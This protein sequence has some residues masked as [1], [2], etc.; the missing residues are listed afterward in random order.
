[1]SPADGKQLTVC[2]E[3]PD[4][5]NAFIFYCF[6]PK[7]EFCCTPQGTL[8]AGVT[9]RNTS[10]CNDDDLVFKAA[11]PEVFA[12]AA[13]ALPHV[14]TSR[15]SSSSTSLGKTSTTISQSTTATVA[16][17]IGTNSKAPTTTPVESSSSQSGMSSGAKAGLGVGITLGVLV[18][19]AIVGAV[20]FLRRKRAN[21]YKDSA[22]LLDSKSNP[23]P[24]VTYESAGTV[25]AELEGTMLPAEMHNIVP[26]EKTPAVT[27]ASR[28]IEPVTPTKDS[29]VQK[30]A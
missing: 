4:H 1:M 17:V 5:L 25:R 12:T 22:V 24:Y 15:S 14:S 21:T 10:C 16:A 6:S 7:N 30:Y 11:A 29:V 27:G 3:E 9:G 28:E 23:P 18:I 13:S 26:I 8:E 2:S 19:L 20:F